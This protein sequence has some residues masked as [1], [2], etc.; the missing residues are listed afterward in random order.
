MPQ[1]S[2]ISALEPSYGRTAAPARRRGPSLR[3]RTGRAGTVVQ[4]S[5]TW[6]STAPAYGKFWQD[7]PG[8]SERKR[9][10]VSRGVC[11]TQSVARQRL[12]EFLEREGVNSKEAYHQNTAPAVTFRHQVIGGLFLFRLASVVD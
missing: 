3:R 12:R 8:S 4:R 1:E 5:K 9:R 11:R 7:L 10:T 6:D 2:L